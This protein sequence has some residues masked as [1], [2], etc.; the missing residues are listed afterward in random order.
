MQRTENAASEN[1]RGRRAIREWF[2]SFFHPETKFVVGLPFI[3]FQLHKRVTSSKP[4]SKPELAK[5]QVIPKVYPM[6]YDI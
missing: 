1:K 2:R 4:T 3:Y 6:F 5:P